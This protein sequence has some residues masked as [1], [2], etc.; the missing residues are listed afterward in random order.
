MLKCNY[1]V[2]FPMFLV[3]PFQNDLPNTPQ[4]VTV[5]SLPKMEREKKQNNQYLFF[6]HESESLRTAPAR[7]NQYNSFLSVSHSLRLSPPSH[8]TLP[9]PP[10]PATHLS[11]LL[12]A[13][14]SLHSHQPWSKDSGRFTHTQLHSPLAFLRSGAVIWKSHIEVCM[15][16]R[17]C[18]CMCVCGSTSGCAAQGRRGWICMWDVVKG[19]SEWLFCHELLM[20]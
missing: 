8:F 7:R 2:S 19:H 9:S 10:M 17:T 11:L 12:S 1:W 3:R 16:A 20:C 6:A 15:H 5:D 14:L 13:A 4:F 18:V